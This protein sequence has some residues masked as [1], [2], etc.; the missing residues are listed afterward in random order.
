MANYL[1]R[2]VVHVVSALIG[3]GLG[4]A[5]VSVVRAEP[6][7]LIPRDALF[8]NP[9]R[10]KP[11][12]SPDGARLAY[13]APSDG[14][15]N[16]WVRTLGQH[17]DRPVTR[18]R[19][20]GI[21]SYFWAQNGKQLI[22]VQDKD[23]DENWHVHAM[24]VETLEDR[25]LTP[26]PGVRADILE[27][28]PR[29][30]DEIVVALNRRDPN[31]HDAFRLNVTTGELVEI[32]RNDGGYIRWVTDHEL[33]VRGALRVRPDGGLTLQ[34]RETA[35]AD[36]RTLTEW[37]PEDTLNS[38]PISF[39][40]N[41]AALYVLSSAGSNAGELR[42]I[43]LAGGKE[44]TLVGDSRYDINNALVHPTEHHIQ[45]VAF[46][47]ERTEWVVLDASIRDDLQAIRRIRR[48]EFDVLSRD[49]A[50]RKW[51]VGFTTDDGPLHYYLYNRED[52]T[53]TLLFTNRKDL[54]AHR[55]ARM[56]PVRF[57]ARDGLT[58]HGYLTTPL[59][60]PERNLP[61][62]LLVHGGPWGRDK[63]G[64]HPEV[65]WLANRGYAV[66]QLNFRGSTG[67]GKE[68][69]NAGN[70]EWGGKM[71]TD[72]LDGVDWAA[73]RGITDPDRVAIFGTSY[74]GYAALVGLASTPERFVCGVSIVGPSNLITF[75]EN[76]PAY[77]KPLEPLF[78]DRIGHPER[79][80][81]MLKARSPLF[82]A[83]RI[84]R[85]L[86]IAQGAND[87]RV[88]KS[89]SL[90]I[91]DVIRKA[92]KE[93]EYVEYAD[94]GHGFAKPSNRLDF[95]ARAEKFLASHLGGRFE[96]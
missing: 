81:G 85:P 78:W 28:L 58:I 91:V 8:G 45:A 1:N 62:V 75:Q 95:Y 9:D 12:L 41:Q 92:G 87:P 61:T 79:D 64:Y 94:E 60:V 59:G 3:I 71:Q 29:F 38:G 42:Q 35:D 53:A 56:E 65:Q 2:P 25:D 84:T 83:D 14:V 20:R 34:I 4:A 67:Y 86:L 19:H 37:G 77:W 80:A 10:A 11:Q 22:Y 40:P 21:Q 51:I 69:I 16:L 23:G 36:W 89:E 74:G 31:V 13:V 18:D 93:V 54:E 26:F 72:L 5:P 57:N 55:L 66:L 15:L 50:D 46:T 73:K 48:G 47:R 39:T 33:R 52:R 30:P 49:V 82:M 32:A 88:R 44:T 96:P 17:D 90:Q 7:P 70:K 24:S 76:I 27:A 68:F 43:E 6:P 63:W